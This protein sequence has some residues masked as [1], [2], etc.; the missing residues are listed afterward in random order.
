MIWVLVS[1]C[2]NWSRYIDEINKLKRLKYK[3]IAIFLIVW[4]HGKVKAF[5]SFLPSLPPS[6][7][8]QT[9]SKEARCSSWSDCQPAGRCCSLLIK[10]SLIN[11]LLQSQNFTD[12]SNLSNELKTYI[13]WSIQLK[14]QKS[15]VYLILKKNMSIQMQI[16][17]LLFNLYLG[18]KKFT[19]EKVDSQ[20]KLI[21]TH[22][23]CFNNWTE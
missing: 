5:I 19:V 16:F 14:F 8:K 21:Q 18:F 4:K 12:A 2:Q 3:R 20:I 7:I 9:H 6:K 11:R 10:L 1:T 17:H 23:Q 22:L 13:R 15:S